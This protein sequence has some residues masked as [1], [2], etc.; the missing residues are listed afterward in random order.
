[1]RNVK[2]KAGMFLAPFHPVEEDPTLCFE[3]DLELARFC[4]DLGMA[5][6]SNPPAHEQRLFF[7]L[8]H[9]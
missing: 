5:E 9:G 2:L 8:R 4:D 1:M 7:G 6:F 3:R